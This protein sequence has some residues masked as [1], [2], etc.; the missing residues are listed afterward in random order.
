MTKLQIAEAEV[1]PDEATSRQHEG[2]EIIFSYR[3]EDVARI[4]RFRDAVVNRLQQSLASRVV[5]FEE[6]VEF[7][8]DHAVGI[9]KSNTL[10]AVKD[11]LDSTTTAPY[12][13]VR[14][15]DFLGFSADLTAATLDFVIGKIDRHRNVPRNC[16]D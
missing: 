15:I 4:N 11:D 2:R 10:V 8:D 5:T 3:E 12:R 9:A 13:I 14:A 1:S 6:L 7:I 16:Q